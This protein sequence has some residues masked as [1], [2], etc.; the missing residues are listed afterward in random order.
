M[1]SEASRTDYLYRS[2]TSLYGLAFLVTEIKGA[3]SFQCCGKFYKLTTSLNGLMTSLWWVFDLERFYFM[4][5]VSDFGQV[6]VKHTFLYIL[7][8]NETYFIKTLTWYEALQL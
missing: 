3:V 6:V 2:T 7:S 4:L 5:M 8:H 1:Y